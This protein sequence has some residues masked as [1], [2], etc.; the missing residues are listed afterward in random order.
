[1]TKTIRTA[2][3]AGLVRTREFLKKGW[4][5]GWFAKTAS[6]R[7]CGAESSDASCWCLSGALQRAFQDESSSEAEDR[8]ASS[9]RWT[10]RRKS[11]ADWNDAKRRTQ[12]QVVGAVTRTIA[13]LRRRK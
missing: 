6:G 7:D 9:L 3:V 4:T 10:I 5:Q 13:R 2:V 8:A 11:I 1:M 12:T